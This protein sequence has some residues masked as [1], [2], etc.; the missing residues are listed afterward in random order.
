[1]RTE[2]DKSSWLGEIM[3]R[4]KLHAKPKYK[5]S[6]RYKLHVT[7]SDFLNKKFILRLRFEDMED[8]KWNTTAQFHSIS[9][10]EF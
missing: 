9:K 7:F 3:R 2:L 6:F 10:E 4:I 8:I 1:M 5:I